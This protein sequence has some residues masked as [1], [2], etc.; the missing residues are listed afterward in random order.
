MVRAE[1]FWGPAWFHAPARWGTVDGYVPFRILWAYWGAL[2]AVRADEMMAAVKVAAYPHL[3]EEQQRE[4]ADALQTTAN[5][6]G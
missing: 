5:G 4:L 6:E 2:D 3:K 1:R